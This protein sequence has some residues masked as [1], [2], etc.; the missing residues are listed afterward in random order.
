MPSTVIRS[1][2]YDRNRRELRIVFQN[3]RAYRYLDVPA[4]IPAALRG[5][6]SKGQFFNQNVRSAFR[7]VADS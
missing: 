6:R 5:A 4:D 1:F 2:R 3:G 7:Y